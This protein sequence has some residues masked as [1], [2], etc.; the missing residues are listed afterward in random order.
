MAEPLPDLD[1][2]WDYADP[3]ATEERF[4]VLGQRAEQEGDL[5]YRAEL[6]TQLARTL[7][8][9]Q[10]FAEAHALLDSVEQNLSAC[11]PRV[12]VRYL[13]ERGR[14]LNSNREPLRAGVLFE[15]AFELARSLELVAWAVDAAH[16]MAI[17]CP[18]RSLEWNLRALELAQD[19]PDPKARRWRGSLHNNLG[20]TWFGRGQFDS[21]LASF[22]EALACRQESGSPDDVF[23]ARW[24][25]ARCLRAQ[26]E[27]DRALAEQ[28]ALER[29]A[30]ARGRP[31]GFVLEEIAECLSGLKRESEARP[32]FARAHELLVQDPWLSRDEPERLARLRALG[33]N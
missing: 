2:L 17:A 1:T 15:E 9:Q 13:L 31:D 33:S 5:S 26:G 32:Y 22:R 27:L 7:G 23:V 30:D 3:R 14:A 10:K 20:W 4:R 29:E 6:A 11:A 12:K 21:A 16:M 24:C 25:V 19:S 18:E 8:L 28:R